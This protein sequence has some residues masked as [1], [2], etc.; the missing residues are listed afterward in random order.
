MKLIKARAYWGFNH[1]EVLKRFNATKFIGEFCI[2]NLYDIP[3][4]IYYSANPDKSK[5]HS[6]YFYLLVDM[7]EKLCIN[8]IEESVIEANRKQIAVHCLECDEVIYSNFRH[9]F[10]TCSCSKVSIDGGKNYTKVSGESFKC[11]EV[12]LIDNTI[13]ELENV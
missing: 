9:N 11:V 12:D 4:A 5:G 2:K 3:V 13:K 10:V 1:K 7:S 6:N 8:S